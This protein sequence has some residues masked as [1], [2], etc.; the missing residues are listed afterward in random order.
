VRYAISDV[1]LL[2][3][4]KDRL[5][6]MLERE[7]RAELARQCFGVIPVLARLDL[8]GYEDVFIH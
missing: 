5:E 6:A 2:L 1:T 4:L 8:M 3:A 7:E